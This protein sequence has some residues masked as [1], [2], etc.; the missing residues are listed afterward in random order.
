MSEHSLKDKVVV[1]TGASAGLGEAMAL[2]LG[3][4]GA[5]IALASRDVYPEP[6]TTRQPGSD[7][8]SPSYGVCQAA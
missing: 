2:A 3:A 4:A 6:M 8:A 1:I 5:S 7:G